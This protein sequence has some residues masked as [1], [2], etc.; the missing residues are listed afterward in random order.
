MLRDYAL[1]YVRLMDGSDG[2][3]RQ[4]EWAIHSFEQWLGRELDVVELTEDLINGYLASTRESLSS[5]TRLSRRNMLLR[6]WR[7]ASTNPAL[8]AR[9]SIPNR[10]LIARVRRIHSAPRLWGVNDCLRLLKE[11]G[12]LQGT[13][14]GGISKPLYWQAWI[15]ASWSSGLRRCDLMQLARKDISPTRRVVIVQQ[16]TGRHVVGEFLPEAMSAID[17]L[18]DQHGKQTIFPLWCSIRCWRK[19]ARRLIRRAGIGG[20]IGKIRGSAGT[21]V[22]FRHPGQGHLFLGNSES[23]FQ[24]HYLDRSLAEELPHP[25]PLTR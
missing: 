4:M 21:A 15:L 7:H 25:P 11:S 13:Y 2:Y 9:P 1:L 17:A 14:R 18:C 24:R 20:S 22:E 10:D 8:T 16:K 3:L 12:K 5:Q 19:I 6:L 23:V